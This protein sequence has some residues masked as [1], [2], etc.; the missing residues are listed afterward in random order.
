LRFDKDLENVR[1]YRR[2]TIGES[3]AFPRVA[4]VDSRL[5]TAS[6]DGQTAVGEVRSYWL[7]PIPP[8]GV[9]HG[10]HKVTPLF[11]VVWRPS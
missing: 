3:D 8:V 9:F 11:T 10:F 5:R 6:L 2:S 7:S 1:G 4:G